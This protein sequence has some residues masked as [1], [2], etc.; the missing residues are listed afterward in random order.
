MFT[1]VETGSGFCQRSE[2]SASFLCRELQRQQP[3]WWHVQ[4]CRGQSMQI[5]HISNTLQEPLLLFTSH[6]TFYMSKPW[7]ASS[8]KPEECR[9]KAQLFW[10]LTSVLVGITWTELW[11]SVSLQLWMKMCWNVSSNKTQVS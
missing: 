2:T 6:L 11:F 1:R 3:A 4:S 10:V 7:S 5:M 8:C 9:C